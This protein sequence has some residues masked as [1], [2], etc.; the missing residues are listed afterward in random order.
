MAVFIWTLLAFAFGSLP[1][2]VW[3]GRLALRAD[4]RQY[5]DHNPGATNVAR[6]GGWQWGALALFLDVLKGA[7]PVGAAWFWGGLSGWEMV[8]VAIAPVLGHAY[9]PFLGFQGGK[10]LATSLGMWGGL[11]A[12]EAP[13]ILVSLLLLWYAIIAVDGWA[14]MLTTFSFLVYLLATDR[15]LAILTIW[16][17][18]TLLLAWKHRADL[19]LFPRLRPWL[20]KLGGQR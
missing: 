4:I 18:N 19:G 3:L 13:L 5:G 16:A 20:S 7:A 9:S 8:P 10:A 6:A 2:S 14:V 17:L 1:F 11:T 15:E 12:G